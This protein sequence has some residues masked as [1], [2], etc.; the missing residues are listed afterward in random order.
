MSSIPLVDLRA[1]HAELGEEVELGFKR[2]LD[3]AAFIGGDE[4]AAFEREYAAFCQLPHC[5]GVANGTDALELALRAVGVRPGHE[6]IIPANTFVATAEAVVRAGARPVL[7]DCDPVTH[8]LDVAAALAAV[9]PA[10]AAIVPVHLY[11]QM[12]PTE[13][14][15]DTGVPVVEDAAQCHGATRHGRAPGAWGVAA[16]SYYPGKNLGAYGDAGAVVTTDDSIAHYVRAVANHGGRAKYQHDLIGCNSRLDALQA[17]VLR[18]KLA[19]LP[20]WNQARR[21]AAARYDALL[22]ALDVRRPTVLE[23]N[24]HVWHLYVI[25]IPGDGRP[26]RRDRVLAR[27]EAAGIAAAIHYPA[28]IHRLP[29]FAHLGY[30]V[31][32]LPHVEAA[33]AEIL[34][35]P[36]HPHITPG[37]QE[38]V[39]DTLADAL[40][41]C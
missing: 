15:A 37:Q 28:P 22:Q 7:V 17:V 31:G 41:R 10:T 35:L 3:S 14:F 21:A 24:D 4:V 1:A 33:A 16:T 20:R 9:G 23:G 19:R 12:A 2:V 27:L 38:F 39:V 5:V 29:A 25:R 6:V 26:D 8:L 40:R 32:V 13:Q 30:P 18:I 34:S 36:L 11:G